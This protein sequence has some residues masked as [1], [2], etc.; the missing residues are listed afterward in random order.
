MSLFRTVNL[1]VILPVE[2]YGD[3][4]QAAQK[5]KFFKTLYL[6]NG[7]GGNQEDWLDYSLLRNL[8]EKIT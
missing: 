6:L 8:A 1:E 5:P 7:F 4:V 2:S 3:K